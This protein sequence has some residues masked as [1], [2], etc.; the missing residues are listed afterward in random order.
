MRYTPPSDTITVA[1]GEVRARTCQ[2]LPTRCAPSIWIDSSS[3]MG[4]WRKPSDERIASLPSGKRLVWPR[5]RTSTS[6][7]IADTSTL[8]RQ[9]L[10]LKPGQTTRFT[11]LRKGK[12]TEIAVAV[13]RRP[14]NLARSGRR[15]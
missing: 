12:P 6:R 8:V 13:G 15:D 1:V 10:S 7:P 14:V 4:T 2:R 3:G 5:R 11:L 9:V